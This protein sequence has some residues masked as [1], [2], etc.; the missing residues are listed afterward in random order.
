MFPR[1]LALF[2]IVPIVELVLL[3]TVGAR[4]GLWP[5]LGI[6]LATAVL[7]AALTRSQGA[8][9]VARAQAA[10][11]SGEL[12][13]AEVLDGLMIVIAGAVL[14]TPGFLTDA[15]GFA[16]LVPPVRAALRRR[17]VRSL[18]GRVQ[19][20]ATAGPPPRPGR[21]GAP[22]GDDTVIEAE[23]VEDDS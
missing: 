18:A 17:L 13:H 2:I 10:A 20:A 7:G 6:I 1:L 22:H 11:A 9:T 5:T 23:L 4:I 8:K 3:F 16:L 19:F 21:P 15:L 14:L 12:P